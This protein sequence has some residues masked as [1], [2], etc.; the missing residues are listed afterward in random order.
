MLNFFILG[1]DLTLNP[2]PE[3][4]DFL[5]PTPSPL[6]KGLGMRS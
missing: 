5:A 4:R 1:I 3:E 6:E 2:S